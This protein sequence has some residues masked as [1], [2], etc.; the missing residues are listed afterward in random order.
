MNETFG[1]N[2]ETPEGLTEFDA[3]V[4][5]AEDN[6]VNREVA[7]F[8]LEILG[9]RVDLAQN[10]VEAVEKAE[11]TPYDL[12]LMDC[13]MPE[14]DG[15]EATRQI[16]EKEEN[17]DNCKQRHMTIIALSGDAVMLESGD[18]L[19]VGMDD[20]LGKPYDINQLCAVIGKWLPCGNKNMELAE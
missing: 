18:Y 9:C 6:P 5:V 13:Q 11:K 1:N 14:M 12:I 3:F 2:P 8:M 20:C 19:T 4:L 7:Q 10:G 17:E 15:I 16:R